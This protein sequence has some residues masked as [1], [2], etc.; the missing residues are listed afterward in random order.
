MDIDGHQHMD[1]D[2]TWTMDILHFKTYL[3]T[4]NIIAIIT[5]EL[6]RS[7]VHVIHSHRFTANGESIRRVISHSRE[8]V[9]RYYLL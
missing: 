9:S 3:R 1:M 8:G 4:L 6:T 2:E 5:Y 7:P